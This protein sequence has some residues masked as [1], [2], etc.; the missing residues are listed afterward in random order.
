MF[1]IN[2]Y[3]PTPTPKRYARRIQE[4]KTFEGLTFGAMLRG[5]WMDQNQDLLFKLLEFIVYLIFSN[6]V[7][8]ALS[9]SSAILR[10]NSNESNQTGQLQE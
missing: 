8:R 2:A 10:F 1:D 4:K 3:K 9:F 7:S 6:E 5:K